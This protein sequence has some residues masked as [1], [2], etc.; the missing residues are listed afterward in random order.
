MQPELITEDERLWTFKVQY[1]AWTRYRG[2]IVK[3]QVR[4]KWTVKAGTHAQARKQIS[5]LATH[6]L[7]TGYA[8]LN[9][10][11]SQLQPGERLINPRTLKILS[12]DI[13]LSNAKTT[14]G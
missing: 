10:H 3:S 5:S 1:Y 8:Q 9:G 6:K 2:V 7:A 12:C 14:P 11:I 4:E 13:N